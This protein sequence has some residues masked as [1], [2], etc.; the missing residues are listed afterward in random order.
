MRTITVS[1]PIEFLDHL[2]LTHSIWGLSGSA[3][4]PSWINR[5][6]WAFRGQERADWQLVPSA[7]RPGT[8]LGFAPDAGVPRAG[9]RERKAQE[10]RLL[11]QFLF[12]AD[13]V[14]LDV[15]GDGQHFRLPQLPGHPPKQDLDA[16]PWEMILETLAVAQHHGVP[17]RLL[18]FSYSPTVAGFFATYG[19]WTKL[20]RPNV[21]GRYVENEAL[22]DEKLAVWGV[23]LPVLYDAVS[24]RSAQNRDPRI[25]LISA[26]RAKNTYL[27]NQ[28]GIF[29]LDLESDQRGYPAMEHAIDEVS[30]EV[31]Q[32]GNDRFASDQVIKIEM[33]WRYAPETLSLLWNEF[34][35][36]AR[37]QP[38][39]D[40]VVQALNDHYDLFRP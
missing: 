11:N 5:E 3:D 25:I 17:T 12:H 26:P 27:H 24:R 1:S 34:Y 21:K 7:F 18:D 39:F 28:E 36:V 23:H 33:A 19:A 15:P 35:H 16:W 14:G 22:L 38:T 31:R 6:I 29:L 37:L 20:G 30:E 4:Y 2:K 40:K 9:S 13:R 8:R 32:Q 10:R